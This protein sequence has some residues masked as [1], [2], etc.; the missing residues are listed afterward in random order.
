MIRWPIEA[1]VEDQRIAR[2]A[3]LAIGLA[4]VE[5]AM[6]SPLP[7]VKP[8]LANIVTLLVLQQYGWRL[9]AW[10]SVLRIIGAALFLGSLFTPGFFLSLC[11]GLASLLMLALA[12]RLPGRWFG[13]VSWSV[14]AA[15]AHMAGQ[16]LFIYAGFVPTAG[17][18]HLAPLLM[19]AALV[20]GWINGLIACR[21]AA[22]VSHGAP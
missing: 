16:L 10:V 5:S 13:L 12:V 9:A 14:L 7:G 8:G 3:V 19:A 11:G 20:F 21:L 2:L 18:W 22:P 15:I 6:P 4:V 17:V 1:T